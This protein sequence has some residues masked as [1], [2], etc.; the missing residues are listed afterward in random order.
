LARPIFLLEPRARLSTLQI[1]HT[2]PALLET[3]PVPAPD[4]LHQPVARRFRAP[5][6]R[7]PLQPSAFRL[8]GISPRSLLSSEQFLDWLEPGVHA[9]LISGEIFM[10]SPATFRHADYVNFLDNLMRRH[11]EEFELGKLYRETAAVRLGPRDTFLPDL[12]YFT[13][14]QAARLGETHADFAPALVVEVLSPSTAK[15][16]RGLKFAAYEAHGVQ[17]YWLI[18]PDKAA[19]RFYRR[20]GDLL[21]EYAAQ[22]EPRIES[23]SLP[24]FWLK[25]EW[26]ANPAR[27]PAVSSCLAEMRS[28]RKTK[29]KP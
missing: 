14:A 17:E 20:A 16:D 19:H 4:R 15:R 11:I 6:P 7:R 29:S 10:H 2:M 28:P 8:S 5:P 18:D 22:N 9:D 25:R 3:A 26:L 12:A 24:G 27:F 23:Q 13:P 21:E 1:L